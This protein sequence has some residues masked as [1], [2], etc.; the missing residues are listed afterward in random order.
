MIKCFLSHSSRDKNF[1]VRM[2]A[3]RLR[4]E[5]KIFDEE[6]FEAGMDTAEEIAKGLDESTLFVIFLSSSALESK[7]VKEELTDAKARFDAAQIQRIYPIIIEAGLKHDDRRIPEWMRES[8]NIQPILKPTIA[9]RK[10]NARLLEL[11]WQSHPRLK[12]RKEIFVGRNELIKQLEER[13]DDFSKEPPIALVASGLSAIGRKTLLQSALKKANLVR[14]SYEFPTITLSALDSIEDFLLKIIDFGMVSVET[15]QFASMDLNEKIEF[16]KKVVSAIVQEGERIIVEDHGVLV[17]NNGELVDW[18]IELLLH[19]APTT[20]LTFCIASQFRL[21]P[22]INRTNPLVYSVTVKELD[23]AER[24][25]L[26][27][28]YSRFHGLDLTRD[29]LS[30]FSD[31]LVG[32]PE[33]VLFAVDLIHD[34]GSFEAK[35]QSHVI[36]QYAS[37]KAQVVLERYKDKTEVLDFI[38]FLCRFEFL[39]YEAL[40]EMVD[41]KIY[42][43]TLNSLL[44]SSV[45]ERIGAS[46]DYVRVSEVIR[47][48]VNRNRFGLPTKFETSIRRHVT[49]FVDNFDDDN[50]DISNYLFSV[51]EAF[52]LGVELPDEILIPSII[53]KTIKRIY[54]NERGYADAIF[55]ADKALLR[56]R[57]MHSATV[58]HIRFIQC[59]SL[60]RLRMQRFFDEVQKIPEPDRSFLYGFYYR[61]TG[62]C[63][64]AEESLIK[65][66]KSNAPRRDP[67]VLGELV[68]VYMQSDEYDKALDLARENYRNRSS[69]P[70]NANNYFACLIMKERTPENRKELEDIITRI[71]ID[72]SERAREMADSMHARI[73]AFFDE[74]EAK[75]LELVEEAIARHPKID[76]PLLTK[77][78]LAAYFE[79]TEKLREAVTAI[80]GVTTKNAQSYRSFIKYKA[81]LL[82]L[83]G[84]NSD[85]KQ[86]VAKEL[87]GLIPSALQRLNERLDLLSNR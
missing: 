78:D 61:L 18:F 80:E 55:L 77:A 32:Y 39:S 31:L 19:L 53:V 63:S 87:N 40:F 48:F 12:E 59:Q 37:D 34:H 13:L 5:V 9:A 6:T 29:E 52:R 20:H 36:Q 46:S 76:Y 67:R 17:Q 66:L 85:A 82:A 28:R 75:S 8:L 62:K 86:L 2:V 71:S 14:D 50:H 54:D 33:Q 26:L 11:S 21:N 84:K 47:D 64:K 22:S 74:D 44:S 4:K 49:H 30:F 58:N 83:E 60:A 69:N 41:V 23:S 38:H 42:A 7:W 81:I 43:D 24:N 35:R 51:Q 65:V 3:S 1:Y 73:V 15:V 27:K 56:E 25:G 16:A 68:L 45:C 70:I 10:I 57:Y 79:N 72:P